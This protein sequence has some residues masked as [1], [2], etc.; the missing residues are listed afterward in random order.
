MKEVK[1]V[2]TALRAVELLEEYTFRR[3][4]G[5]TFIVWAV[6]IAVAGFVGLKAE[7]IAR[8]IEV[9]SGAL[10]GFTLLVALIAGASATVYL[11]VSAGRVIAWKKPTAVPSKK[12]LVGATIGLVWFVLTFAAGWVG[13]WI[14]YAITW[15]VCVG[16]ANVLTYA[17][18][19][20]LGKGYIEWLI[21]GIILLVAS[22]LIL[23]AEPADLAYMIALAAIVLAYGIGG[24]CSLLAAPGA[25]IGKKGPQS[26]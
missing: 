16:L 8:A 24:I 12:R 5:A 22:P 6:I 17:L 11:F 21:V 15:P 14:G 1:K 9:D 3:A 10:I 23:I 25:L 26:C 4:L 13:A 19:R 20:V 7:T 18:T 2:E